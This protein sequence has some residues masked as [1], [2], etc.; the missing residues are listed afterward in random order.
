MRNYDRINAPAPKD[1]DQKRAHIIG[2]GIAGLSAAIA[3]VTDAHMPAGNVTI[4][5]SSPN[6]GGSMDGAGDSERGYTCRGERELEA[7]MECLWYI[8]SK[9]P[10]LKTPGMTVLD[11][12]YYANVRERIHSKYR[13][14]H[15]TGERYDVSGPLMSVHD[16]K[17]MAEL[18]LTPEEELEGL[19][20]ADWFS[21]DFP[22][23]IFWL[24][25]A[26]M[27]SFHTY[28]SLI[29][30]KRYLTRF[31]MYSSTVTYLGGILH[32]EYNEYDSIIK[33][34]LVWLK[35]LGV[36]FRTGVTITDIELDNGAKETVVTALAL[37]EAGVASRLALSRDDLVF[38][39]NG[40]LT[41][42]SKMGDTH[43]V[44]ALDRDTADR[45]SFT[46][47]EK[48]AA[49]DPKFG[50]PSAFLS[51][52]DKTKWVSFFPTIK[53]DATFYD[54]MERKT[55][56]KTGTGGIITVVD[57]SWKLS[58]I[59]YS[60]YFPNQPDDV[61][62][63]W[64]YGLCSDVPGDFIK[65][66]MQECTGAEMFAELL[67]HCG[68]KDQIDGILA[69]SYV[70]TAMM[71]YITSQ[72]M[73]RKISD[74]PTVIPEGCVNLAFMGQFVELPLDVVFTVE[75]SVRTAL[76]GVWGLTGLQKPMI[77]VYEP[78]YDQRVIVANLKA[79]L[80]IDKISLPTL[81]RVVASSPS[82]SLVAR[83]LKDMP[84]PVI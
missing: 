14:M 82:L 65:K 37:K 80:G 81:P 79:A 48:L 39:T 35:S 7:R 27:L 61:N 66:P 16:A 21:P 49:I 6:V 76:M 63:F 43:T 9:V 23:S 72:F 28:H 38:F 4:Y 46:V 11:E 41:Q 67:Y 60:K 69:H 50:N 59:V 24:C 53:G 19:T 18:M 2:G 1:I 45:G 62:A 51:D 30:V 64:A 3:L 17:R 22:K 5:E 73:P 68:L 8:C 26:A 78:N 56:N 29:E 83:Q 31:S 12:T 13:L 74:R 36:N 75:T 32:T 52:I 10:S 58:F 44:A 40:S 25:W 77:P 70:S 71:P 57:S 84:A 15:K 42:K 33:P 55:G 47:W 20:V 54:Y 34:M